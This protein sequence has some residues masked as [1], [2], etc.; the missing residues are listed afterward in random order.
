MMELYRRAEGLHLNTPGLKKAEFLPQCTCFRSALQGCFGYSALANVNF[1]AALRVSDSLILCTKCNFLADL[2]IRVLGIKNFGIETE[3]Q[4]H[5]RHKTP[6]L[7]L[8]V[9]PALFS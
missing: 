2:A 8:Y 5:H 3:L 1:L 9:N 6:F 7:E 4:K